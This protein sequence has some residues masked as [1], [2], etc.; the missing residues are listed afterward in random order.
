M[1][2]T[3]SLPAG[4]AARAGPDRWVVRHT[5]P[6]T[7]RSRPGRG[8]LLAGALAAVALVVCTSG[9]PTPPPRTASTRPAARPAAAPAF[10]AAAERARPGDPNWS[11]V[12]V[13][14][15]TDVEGDA[16]HD[17]MVPGQPVRL[18]VSTI[19]HH[20]RVRAYRMG[21]YGGTRARLVWQ[22]APVP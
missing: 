13:G 20:V 2:P 4:G 9:R 11:V 19:A 14:R 21:W 1:S 3:V 5:V 17:R 10:P 22:S 6:M 7:V 18:F 8:A 16:D 15:Q 12:E